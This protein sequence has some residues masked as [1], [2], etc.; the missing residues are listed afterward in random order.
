MAVPISHALVLPD[1]SFNDWYKATDAYTKAFE[2]V[3]IVRTPAG[4]DLNRFRNVTAVET[5]N[6]W[7]DDN[8]LEHIKRIY[9]SVVRVDR[10]RITRPSELEA[11]LA[12]RIQKKDRFGET[13]SEPKHLFTRF[14][15]GWPS[16]GRP[17]RITRP[18]NASDSADRKNEGI[19]VNAPTGAIIRAVT[20]GKV[21]AVIKPTNATA[22]GHYVQV[23]TSFD[24]QNYLITYTN[25]KNIG[26]KVND[27]V[28]VGDKI[29]ES[30]GPAI[31]LI[32]QKPGGGLRGYPLP[33][34]LDPTPL[35]YWDGLRLRTTVDGLRIR[36]RPGLQFP[37]KG[38]VYL[39]DNIEAMELH[40]HTLEK[41][42]VENKWIR[43]RTPVGIQGF[44]AA[45]YMTAQGLDMGDAGNMTGMNLDIQHHLGRPSP[46]RMK[47]LGWVRFAYNVSQ[48]TGSVDFDMADRLYRPYIQRYAGEGLRPIIVLGH[49]TYGEGRGY[50]WPQ[51]TPDKWNQYATDFANACREVARRY[52]GTNLIGAYQIWNEQDTPAHLAQSAVALTPQ[53]Y[54]T[55]LTAAIRAIRSVD[56]TAKIITG[57]HIS[58]A[59]AGPAYA[60]ATIALM[61]S[62]IRP[63]GIAFHA[64][65]L[66]APNGVP[67]YSQ[68]GNIGPVVRAYS[69][70]I[71]APVWI[72]EWGVLDV[73]NEP[74]TDMSKYATTFIRD[75]KSN[76][77][78]KVAAAVWYAWADTMHNGYG[79]VDRNDRPKSP[80]YSDF[81]QA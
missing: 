16:D 41:V 13:T 57:G 76:F 1:Q 73:P 68:Y 36:E 28:E 30:S 63:D 50:V 21:A 72:T 9:P 54:G 19:D 55:I 3:V 60:R 49:Q 5:I 2:R 15:V 59:T 37:V 51:M 53:V 7:L 8:A 25:L 4:Y 35:L 44:A 18:F 39:F 46:D 74:A 56:T 6:V 69:Q 12:A 42:G 47:G 11:I 45:W 58:G 80:L 38:Q 20:N 24:S 22:Y 31:K 43:V 61:P 26:V 78:D 17:A 75:L 34:V 67:R 40:G 10:I 33:D 77:P 62:N 48:G 70:V 71:D 65:G 79:L 32:I 29:A 27:E 52:A 81:L 23:V 14:V 66:G 64:Y